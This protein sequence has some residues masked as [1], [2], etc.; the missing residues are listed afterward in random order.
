LAGPTQDAAR[1]LAEFRPGANIY[2][3]GA[4]GEPLA[5]RGI[6][7]DTPGALAGVS[8]TSCLL[9]GMNEF[10][11]AALNPAARL[12]T[13]MLPAALRSS[14]EAGGVVVRPMAYSQIAAW[15]ASAPAP[16]LA[17]LQVTPPD[18]RGLCSLG[19][20]ADFA[21]LVW[22]RARRRLAFVNANLPYVRRGPTI[23]FDAIDVAVPADGPFITGPD[24]PTTD[25]QRA[26]AGRIATLIP[27]GAAIQTGIGGAPAA[28][29]AG[30]A[31]RRGL[32]VRSGMVTEGYHAL[33]EAGALDPAAEHITGLALGDEDFMRW[34]AETLT[35]AD[36]T[37]TH[38]AAS[39]AKAE[40]L[41]AINS[42]L[43]VDLFGQANIEWRGGRLMSG[44]GGAPD[45]ARAARR[46]NGG[47]AILALPATTGRGAISRI[48]GR[49]DAPTVSIPRDDTDLII[50]EHGV[51]DLR[52][53]DL[54]SRAR[55]LI[56][57]AAPAHR[58]RLAAEWAAI[59]RGL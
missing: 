23:P 59:R 54:E 46:S 40:R 50:T 36:A 9:P 34:A 29:L 49:L 57:I 20:C 42:A 53:V 5:L 10:D 25:E 56:A 13:F 26:I 55:S 1:V 38:G 47:R 15:L 17:I 52:G 22:P 4:V 3:Q 16:D 2:L 33:A 19:P 18:A 41:Y 27:D 21:P 44:L 8:L 30:L 35:F 14:F 37:V 32:I 45:F 6:L 11:Y 24:A 48:V 39:L 7:S 28:A 51:A 31:D 43:E 58:E 12:T